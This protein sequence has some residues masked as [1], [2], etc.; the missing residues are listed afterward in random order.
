MA[1]FCGPFNKTTITLKIVNKSPLSDSLDGFFNIYLNNSAFV[2]DMWLDINGEYKRAVNLNAITAEKIYQRIVGKKKDPAKLEKIEDGFFSLEVFPVNRSEPRYVKI[3]FYSLAE[4]RD[5]SRQLSWNLELSGTDNMNI[6]FDLHLP[7]GVSA[8]DNLGRKISRINNILDYHSSEV[9]W[10]KCKAQIIFDFEKAA[11]KTSLYN[12]KYSFDFE[13]VRGLP[14]IDSIYTFPEYLKKIVSYSKEGN[15]KIFSTLR[16]VDGFQSRFNDYLERYKGIK[17]EL[18]SLEDKTEWRK[19]GSQYYFRNPFKSNFTELKGK[20]NNGLL[21][22]LSKNGIKC[23]YLNEIANYIDE[24]SDVSASPEKN[25]YLQTNSSKLVLEDNELTRSIYNE[26]MSKNDNNTFQRTLRDDRE[27]A[28]H[29]IGEMP[30]YPAG[31][32][33]LL[34]FLK[35][36]T[37]YPDIAFRA[38]VEGKVMVGFVVEKDGNVTN[39]SIVKGIGTIC[40][41]EALRVVRLMG[42]WNN[43]KSN[44][45]PL[46]QRMVIPVK[47]SLNDSSLLRREVNYKGRLFHRKIDNSFMET[48]FN[49]EN[50]VK[51]NFGSKEYF[52]ILF[53][54]PSLIDYVYY[55]RNVG[56]YDNM[57]KKWILFEGN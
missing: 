4:L 2:K 14:V 20:I 34:N 42:K 40:D 50:S 13:Y 12:D 52:D 10:R 43:S 28:F 31:Q 38:Q 9:N 1:E 41:E 33:G 35:E 30:S 16:L 29:F 36:N 22:K 37:F 23:Y 32:E 49:F 5:L 47:F 6:T 11:N 17:I 15:K 26:V 19:N 27:E 55:L 7:K 48:G 51:V 46:R 18:N 24:L 53:E 21:G 8:R 44:G 54:N 45:K 39:I 56:L 57:S 25:M 3:E